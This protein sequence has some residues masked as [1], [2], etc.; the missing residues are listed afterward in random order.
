MTIESEF[1]SISILKQEP[2]RG[3]VYPVT[4]ETGQKETIQ[5]MENLPSAGNTLIGVSVFFLLNVAA[6]RGDA[7]KALMCIDLS[8]RV[9]AFWYDFKKVIT[10]SVTIEETTR[11]VIE[12]V[13]QKASVY[14]KDNCS[15]V[16]IELLKREISEGV[17]WL[18]SD[19]R[20]CRIK[21]IFA[22]GRFV[23]MLADLRNAET[24]YS[25]REK[26]TRIGLV[27][28]SVYLSNL[29]DC[30]RNS[31]K[32]ELLLTSVRNL[33]WPT[34]TLIATSPFDCPLLRCGKNQKVFPSEEFSS[35]FAAEPARCSHEKPAA[36]PDALPSPLS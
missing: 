6:V 7:I 8:S 4:N 16:P 3:F 27:A 24:T 15:Q 11:K 12:L 36:K 10:S 17:S 30:N 13:T 19:E 21:R 18:S 23:F 1:K 35:F 34:T 22:E 14:F 25:I 2:G 31:A 20:F 5:T 32:K 29:Y 28:D 26:M 9:E 33:L